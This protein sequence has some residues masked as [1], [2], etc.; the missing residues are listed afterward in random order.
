MTVQP[1]ETVRYIDRTYKVELVRNRMTIPKENIRYSTRDGGLYGEMI[2]QM[3]AFV[4]KDEKYLT[5]KTPSTWWDHF[6]L[7]VMPTWTR[8]LF[9]VRY[10]IKRFVATELF[11]SYKL[12]HAD[13]GRGFVTFRE[14]ESYHK[15]D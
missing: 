3:D 7:D 12:A 6:K 5:V 15:Y 10:E 11:P 8:G 14:H 13:I 1:N 9:P 2:A 4:L